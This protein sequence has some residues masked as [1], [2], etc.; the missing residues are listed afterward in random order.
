MERSQSLAQQKCSNSTRIKSCNNC[1]KKKLKCDKKL[2]CSRCLKKNEDQTC[3][4]ESH[5][6]ATRSL[7]NSRS[8]TEEV[9]NC[10]RNSPKEGLV[11]LSRRQKGQLS[12][13]GVERLLEQFLK[14]R[15]PSNFIF[16]PKPFRLPANIKDFCK[17]VPPYQ[18]CI[19]V[20]GTLSCSLVTL[21]DIISESRMEAVLHN[22]F[23]NV[24]EVNDLILLFST[25]SLAFRLHNLPATA[26]N[27]CGSIQLAPE[28][29]AEEYYGKAEEL[30]ELNELCRYQRSIEA[31][32]HLILHALVEFLDPRPEKVLCLSRAV[33]YLDGMISRGLFSEATSEQVWKLSMT[34]K[35]LD[36][37][38]CIFLRNPPFLQHDIV[39]GKLRQLDKGFAETIYQKLL[40]SLC[41]QGLT[42]YRYANC[43]SAEEYLLNVNENEVKISLL[44]M[45]IDLKAYTPQNPMSKIQCFFLKS[46][47]W[48]LKVLLYQPVITLS[49]EDFDEV[50][51]LKG[52]LAES[53][54]CS[55]RLI[56]D[57]YQ[58][59][60][61]VG[62]HQFY[63]YTALRKVILLPFCRNE[64][65]SYRN[66]VFE[67]IELMKE[68]SLKLK[69]KFALKLLD[70]LITFIKYVYQEDT[71]TEGGSG[72]VDD[73]EVS[74][75]C[76][77]LMSNFYENSFLSM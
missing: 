24:F 53:L 63:F 14:E 17:H 58:E 4:Y 74:S 42:I 25:L 52:K 28:K 9:T 66:E 3:K 31:L 64:G 23:Q 34:L 41:N 12:Y 56:M 69:Y 1:R 47:L 46:V 77:F 60:T 65:Y 32:Q 59:I 15:I 48:T 49:D 51:L 19:T 6:A 36:S 44:L 22:F 76:E 68:L 8:P 57:S 18:I 11:E 43:F 67:A 70:E 50:K 75:F 2:P 54:F 27:Y 40:S 26:L 71:T 5:F 61:E 73:F 33:H 21:F 45:E 29:L 72:S 37:L 62:L 38:N 16:L 55:F 7:R 39:V 10:G 30:I 20:C 35:H 13:H